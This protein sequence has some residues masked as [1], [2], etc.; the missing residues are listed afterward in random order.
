MKFISEMN[1]SLTLKNESPYFNI[2]TNKK[3]Y[4]IISD[5]EKAFDRNLTSIF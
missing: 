5:T 4:I 1:T 3:S 2:L